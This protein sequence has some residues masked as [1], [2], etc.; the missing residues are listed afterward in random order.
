MNYQFFGT[1]LIV[2]GIL[3]LAGFLFVSLWICDDS[4]PWYRRKHHFGWFAVGCFL[5]IF[6]F[7]LIVGVLVGLDALWQWGMVEHY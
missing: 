2:T 7:W 5:S 1:A 4:M 3:V 6:V